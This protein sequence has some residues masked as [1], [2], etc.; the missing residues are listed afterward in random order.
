MWCHVELLIAKSLSIGI[1]Y[2]FDKID[3]AWVGLGKWYVPVCA[4]NQT[5]LV[6]FTKYFNCLI[7]TPLRFLF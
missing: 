1:F 6:H 7:K 4:E 3:D 2:I 5:P